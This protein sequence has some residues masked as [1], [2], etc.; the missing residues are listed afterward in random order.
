MAGEGA[1]FVLLAVSFWPTAAEPRPSMDAETGTAKLPNAARIYHD[2]NVL[3]GW[4]LGAGVAHSPMNQ[5]SY[6]TL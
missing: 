2:V 6:N 5:R 4:E 1:P 3:K